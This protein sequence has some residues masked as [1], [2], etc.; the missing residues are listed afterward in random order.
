MDQ[1][2]YELIW[3]LFLACI[4]IAIEH[5]IV[6]YKMYKYTKKKYPKVSKLI[7]DSTFTYRDLPYYKEI[8]HNSHQND[9]KYSFYITLCRI[10]LLLILVLFV[11][12]IVLLFI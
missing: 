5:F 8:F 11:T 10:N 9:K 3:I 6:S 1:N 7:K 12:T 2:I 4:V